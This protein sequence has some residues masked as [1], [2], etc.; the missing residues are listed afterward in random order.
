MHG[1]RTVDDKQGATALTAIEDAA[2]T[3][4]EA[5]LL[6]A[7][8]LGGLLIAGYALRTGVPPMPTG[9]GTRRVML[10]LLP[11]AVDGTIYDLGSGWGGLARALAARHPHN[12]VVGIE[13]SP[14]PW[15]FA[16]VMLRL[17]PLP[18]LDFR[19]GDVL[20]APLGDAGAVAFYLMP[21]PLRRLAPK[22]EAELAP[23]TPVVSNG[24]A[25]PGWQPRATVLDGDTGP[26]PVYR[27]DA[28]GAQV[29]PA[30]SAWSPAGTAPSPGMPR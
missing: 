7:L 23:G 18:N 10:R 12:R 8:L 27:Y 15:L 25:V 17:R 1:D 11:A 22:L 21:G 13:L 6:I 5:I 20:S 3:G 14:L 19:R 2:V 28:P 30:P 4:A 29:S 9:P 24:F 26:S 16:A